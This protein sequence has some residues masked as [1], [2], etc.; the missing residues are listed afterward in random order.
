MHA[1]LLSV[2]A[3]LSLWIIW[4]ILLV[5]YRLYFHP[6]SGIPGRKLACATQ[7]YEFYYDVLKWPGGQYWYEVDK[8]HDRYGKPSCFFSMSL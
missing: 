2:I 4:G 3:S 8:M 7:W 6:L 5:V 1:I